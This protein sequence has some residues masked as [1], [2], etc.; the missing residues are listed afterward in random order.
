MRACGQTLVTLVTI[1]IPRYVFLYSLGSHEDASWS[2][3]GCYLYDLL[4]ITVPQMF[5][6]ASNWLTLGKF[7]VD[8]LHICKSKLKIHFVSL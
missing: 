1:L 8:L 3:G 5:H 7:K 6:T 2:A 4:C